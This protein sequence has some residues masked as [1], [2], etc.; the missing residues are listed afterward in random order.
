MPLL[1][2]LADEKDSAHIKRNG[3]KTGKKRYGIFCMPVLPNFYVSHQWL[4]ELKREGTKTFVGIYF[5]CDS[6]ELV[7]AGKYNSPHEEMQLGEAIKEIMSLKDPLGYELIIERKINPKEIFK[8]KKLPQNIGW[9]YFSTS[10]SSKPTCSCRVCIP[11][12]SIKGRQLREKIDPPERQLAYNEII[13]QICIEDDV[14][15]IESLL[16]NIGKRKRRADPIALA[17]LL[18]INSD[19]INQTLA[20]ILKSFR[21]KNS[22]KILMELLNNKDDCTRE[23]AADTLLTLYGNDI[24]DLLLEMNDPLIDAAIEDWRN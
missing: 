2:H 9:R 7:L 20:L 24:L 12:G 23:F 1:V 4:R 11:P 13:E 16:W 17:L 14:S 18:D 3:L 22:K 19:D 10:H 15:K 8:I 6:R 21:H 5:K